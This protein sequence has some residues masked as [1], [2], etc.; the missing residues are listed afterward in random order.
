MGVRLGNVGL[1]GD[2]DVIIGFKSP[3]LDFFLSK[4]T[5]VIHV[6]ANVGQERDLYAAHDLN[7]FWIEPIPE[8]F[9][10]LTQRIGAFPKQRASCSLI[11]DVE[12]GEYR[13]NIS[14]NNGASSSIFDFAQHT[15][16]WPDVSFERDITLKSTT[17]PSLLKREHIDLSKYNA[18]VMDT[19]GSE[20]LILKGA[21]DI[22]SRF[23][24]I[25]TEVA[26]FESYQNCCRLPDMD[27]FLLHH[28]FRRVA[29]HPFAHKEGIGSYFDV[30]YAAASN[31]AA[32]VLGKGSEAPASWSL[33]LFGGFELSVLASGERVALPGKH[34]R[35]LLAYLAL[36]PNGRAARRKLATLLWGDATDETALDNLHTCEWS[37]RKVLGDTEHRVI[38]S[39]GEDILLDVRAFDVDALAFRRLAAQSGRKELEA[40]AN[41]YAGD[42][43]AGLDIDSEE[44][45]SWRCSEATR[46]RDQIIDVFIRK[47]GAPISSLELGPPITSIANSQPKQRCSV[48]GYVESILKTILSESMLGAV[49]YWRHPERGNRW[50]GP[51]NGQ[52]VR[53]ALFRSLIAKLRPCAIIETGTYQ[54]TTTKF[55]AH[56]GLP[57]FTVESHP[58]N[59]GFSR[60]RL[61]RHSRV[62]VRRGDSREFLR[63]LFSGSFQKF[64]SKTIF[65]YLDAHW[66]RDLPL[67]DEIDLVFSHCPAAVIMIDDF[68]VPFDGGYGYDDYGVGKALIQTYIEPA[69]VNHG[70]QAFYPSAPASE[71][72]GM[73]RGCVVLVK[74]TLHAAV[75]TSMPELRGS[76][77]QPHGAALRDS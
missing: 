55:M 47:A 25:K 52:R 43:L 57:I 67:A 28:Q 7:V 49:D 40:A 29:T 75:L 61:L 58:Y 13:F 56:T 3:P 72:T 30:T 37:L 46:S 41:V 18:L 42:L 31:N 76:E 34:E 68:R 36:S 39:D 32:S 51:F 11:T 48:E 10:E 64:T 21:V 50:G 6:G 38:A 4:V 35:V 66:E 69:I 20:L 60:A 19:Q 54:G 17:L 73:R 1:K 77:S 45:K 65:A 71:E 2:W 59:Y 53:A 23:R 22:L 15:E 44:F 12:D 62:T 8:V 9:A 33:R 63:E 26:D 24:F 16:I 14:N 74:K 27:N 5:G 70:L